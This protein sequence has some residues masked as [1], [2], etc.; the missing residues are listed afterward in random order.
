[1]RAKLVHED[2]DFIKAGHQIS[3]A[4]AGLTSASKNDSDSHATF[5]RNA[6]V[7]PKSSQESMRLGLS[8]VNNL[9]VTDMDTEDAIDRR[10]SIQAVETDRTETSLSVRLDQRPESEMVCAQ[11]H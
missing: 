6:S 7:V 11:Q 9:S 5:E 3:Q 4:L 8:P 1:V 2:A 10:F